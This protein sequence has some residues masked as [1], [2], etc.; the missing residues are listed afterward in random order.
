[1]IA[2]ARSV[3]QW[4]K[5]GFV[6]ILGELNKY[7]TSRFEK[8]VELGRPQTYTRI[9]INDSAAMVLCERWCKTLYCIIC[10]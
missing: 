10:D 6:R 4:P 8:V 9:E 3:E 7:M 1:M 5:E 2:R